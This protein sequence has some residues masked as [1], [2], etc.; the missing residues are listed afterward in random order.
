[1]LGPPNAMDEGSKPLHFGTLHQ[2]LTRGPAPAHVF[3][4]LACCAAAW[5][6]A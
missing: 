1:M 6:P 5:H 3:P 4:N 2:L